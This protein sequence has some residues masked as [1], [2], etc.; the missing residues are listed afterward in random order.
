MEYEC[1]PFFFFH[2]INAFEKNHDTVVIDIMAYKNAEVNTLILI[3]KHRSVWVTSLR[4][5]SMLVIDAQIS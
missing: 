4:K 1:M 3:Y 2:V 5:W